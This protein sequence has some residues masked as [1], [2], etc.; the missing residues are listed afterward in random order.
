MMTKDE[1][2][3]D[4]LNSVADYAH[5]NWRFGQAVFNYI[6]TQYGVARV[7]QFDRHIDCFYDDSK[8]TAFISACYDVLS[9]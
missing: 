5:T 6:D 9:K 2:I 7:V 4:V 8:V 3:T 1:F